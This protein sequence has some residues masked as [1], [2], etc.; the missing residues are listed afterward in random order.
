MIVPR[1]HDVTPYVP[2]YLLLNSSH[3]VEPKSSLYETID[4][5]HKQDKIYP[6]HWLHQID[7][8]LLCEWRIEPILKQ[9]VLFL[10]LIVF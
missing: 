7:Q 8:T 10:R 1:W 5:V 4:A 2:I 3:K 6:Y 9:L